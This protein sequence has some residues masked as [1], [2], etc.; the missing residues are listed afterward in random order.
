MILKIMIL[1]GNGSIGFGGIDGIWLEVDLVL[2]VLWGFCMFWEV[3][4]GLGGE[5]RS[6]SIT[7]SCNGLEN[8]CAFYLDLSILGNVLSS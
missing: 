3:V 7:H 1:D 4:D 5:I 2:A 6:R 8:W